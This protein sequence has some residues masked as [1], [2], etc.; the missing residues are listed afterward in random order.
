MPFEIRSMQ[1]F[2]QAD[3]WPILTGYETQEIYTVD[4]T[5]TDQQTRIDIRL[6]R[7]DTPFQDSFYQDFPPEECE[8][9]LGYLAQGYSF[10]AYQ[11][12]RLIGF[13]L[14]EAQPEEHM[15]RVWEFHVLAEFR[16]MGVGRALMAQVIAKTRQNH[17]PVILLETQNTNVKAIRFYRS[18]G[19]SLESI[20]LSPPHYVTA[21]GEP[22]NQIAFYMKLRL[23][24]APPGR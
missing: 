5:E 14:A 13:A 15:V 21:A 6:V 8:R 19:Y 18:M 17:L 22:T 4:K 16:R 3:L 11:S 1:P 2:T 20:D 12:E 24:A 23:E 9:Y 7:L 10:G